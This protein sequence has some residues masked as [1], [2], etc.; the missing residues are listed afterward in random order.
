V[1]DGLGDETKDSVKIH[2][3]GKRQESRL[4]RARIDSK[5][6]LKKAIELNCDIYHFHDPELIKIGVYL[7]KKGK[8][9]LLEEVFLNYLKMKRA[10]NLIRD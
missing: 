10:N 7:K 5:K 3:I 6:A 8:I 4:K 2:D 9:Y 1:A